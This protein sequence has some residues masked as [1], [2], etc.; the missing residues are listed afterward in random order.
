MTG[1]GPHVCHFVCCT[2]PRGGLRAL[3]RPSGAQRQ[4]GSQRGA[5]LLA[6]MLTVT[7]VA[8]L[9]AAALWQQW[10]G[11][12]VE[13]AERSR[14]QSSWIL[15]GALD[16]SRLILR[17]DKLSSS[18]TDNLSEPW[19]TP[20]AEARL[21][22]FLSLDSSASDDSDEAFLS[23]QITDAQARMNVMNLVNAQKISVPAHLAFLKLFDRL[24]IAAE[25]LAAL[26]QNLLLALGPQT[27]ADVPLLPQRVDEL[28]WLG[29]LPG[30]IELIKPYVTILPTTTLV[31]LNTASAEV[32]DAIFPQ[33]DL[34]GARRLVQRR[35]IQPFAKLGDVAAVVGTLAV[36]TTDSAPYTFV[37]DYFEVHGRLRLDQTV[38]EERSLVKRTGSDVATVWRERWVSESS[39]SDNLP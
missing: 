6:A 1:I 29:L 13:A 16:F 10:R 32:I 27:D 22:T 36:Q 7:L 8:T 23:G 14:I 38:L 24:G 4:A 18:P 11:V 35:Q 17:E 33:M 21:S 15:T 20:L 5:A 28:A 39:P 25:Q 31:N 19:A 2:A 3:G 26:E 37:T 30:N 9:A 12:E 34:S